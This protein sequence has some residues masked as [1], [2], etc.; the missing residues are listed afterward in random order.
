VALPNW[1]SVA[2]TRSISF[3]DKLG[4]P[5]DQDYVA[6]DFWNQKLLGVFRNQMALEVA[7]HDTRVVLVHPVLGRP[8]LIG[9]SR[10]ITGACSIQEMAWDSQQNV[11]RGISETVEGQR[12]TLFL[13]VPDKMSAVRAQASAKSQGEVPVQTE[14]RGALL[15]IA[16]PGGPAPVSWEIGFAPQ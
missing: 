13:Y 14:R 15:S 3:P 1:R 10:H 12:Y 6:F 11:L 4:L 9:L 2:V 5:P 7:G 16:F 8:Q